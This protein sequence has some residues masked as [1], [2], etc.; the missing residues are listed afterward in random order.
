MQ[1]LFQHVYDYIT[2]YLKKITV[3]LMLETYFK[4][5][6]LWLYNFSKFIKNKG[7][8]VYTKLLCNLTIHKVC[9]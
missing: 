2:K 6:W 3:D 1:I 7:K 8:F 5:M 4:D 9:Y